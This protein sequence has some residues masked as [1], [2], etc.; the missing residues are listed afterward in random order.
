MQD[1]G[2]TSIGGGILL[3]NIQN[4]RIFRLR[5]AGA[6]DTTSP[7]RRIPCWQWRLGLPR[8]DLRNL[9]VV[10]G[11]ARVGGVMMASLK[12]SVSF[13]SG[14]VALLGL[15]SLS[16]PAKAITLN[17]QGLDGTVINFAT[18]STFNFTSIGGYQFSISSVLGGVGDAVKL[19]GFVSPG[20]PFAI[21][22]ITIAGGLQSAAVTGTGTLH[23]TDNQTL[24]LTGTI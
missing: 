20:G 18:N 13:S 14:I 22:P 6:S 12:R 5:Y 1:Y 7:A 11:S 16:L 24:D 15:L 9:T 2:R 21:G 10:E 4:H 8:D 23:I 3:K 17:F 19:D